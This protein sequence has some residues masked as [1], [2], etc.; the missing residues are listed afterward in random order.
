M[1]NTYHEGYRK[2]HSTPRAEAIVFAVDGFWVCEFGKNVW[3]GDDVELVAGIGVTSLSCIV[4][5]GHVMV[6]SKHEK[7]IMIGWINKWKHDWI[8]K[9]INEHSDL[10]AER[11]NAWLDE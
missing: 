2:S 11:H 10:V 6:W 5:E 8:N 4:I 7:D 1:F 9:W 3:W